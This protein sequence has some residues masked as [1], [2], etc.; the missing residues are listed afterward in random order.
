[1]GFWAW[2]FIW[3]ALGLASLVILGLIGK[4]LFNKSLEVAHQ[5][6]K[7]AT[8]AQKLAD[9]IDSRENPIAKPQSVL[10]T[11]ETASTQRR[12]FLKAKAKKREDR[13]RILIKSLKKFDPNESR[14]H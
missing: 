5:I 4:S 8:E 12:S 3:A 13:T 1:M 9:L 11:P 2:F 6:G 14:F 7:V 10:I